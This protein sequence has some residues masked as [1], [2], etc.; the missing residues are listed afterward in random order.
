MFELGGN[1]RATDTQFAKFVEE[2][3]N[4]LYKGKR[5]PFVQVNVPGVMMRDQKSVIDSIFPAEKVS[6]TFRENEHFLF[7]R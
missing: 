7:S 4:G 3:G 6:L 2:V 1:K 5:C